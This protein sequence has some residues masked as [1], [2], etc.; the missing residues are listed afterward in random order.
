MDVVTVQVAVILN[1]L[2][3]NT[4]NKTLKDLQKQFEA[5]NENPLIGK[6]VV[7]QFEFEN[8]TITLAAIC[9]KM[10]VLENKIALTCNGHIIDEKVSKGEV[11]STKVTPEDN[12][13][14]T[15][16]KTVFGMSIRCPEDKDDKIK[17]VT[18]ATK[19]A[20]KLKKDLKE[21]S[22]STTVHGNTGAI[23]GTFV[24]IKKDIMTNPLKYGVW[25]LPKFRIIKYKAVDGNMV[26]SGC[27]VNEHKGKIYDT[28][29]PLEDGEKIQ[30]FTVTGSS[31]E[32]VQ[33]KLYKH[34][35]LIRK[36]ELKK[37]LTVSITTDEEYKNKANYT[38]KEPNELSEQ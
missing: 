20:Y 22:F 31:K 15:Y 5:D 21:F 12:V 29:P 6:A 4:M 23:A 13:V 38:D 25:I 10:S 37:E 8:R 16:Y 14:N 11:W 36:A 18:T 1:V 17:A 24:A 19:R 30:V 27:F 35:M 3:N 26:Y 33:Q 7:Y 28:T 32:E 34:L 9:N 2:N